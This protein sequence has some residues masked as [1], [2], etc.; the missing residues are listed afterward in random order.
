MPGLTIMRRLRLALL[1]AVLA[2]APV[3]A[4]AEPTRL[5]AMPDVRQHTVYACGAAALQAIIAYYGGDAR[6]DTLMRELG[7]DPKIGTRYWEIVRVAGQYGLTATTE[8]GMSQQR[9]AALIDDG[10]PVILAIQAW[11]S[12]DPR[13]REAWRR[14]TEDGHYLIAIGYDDENFY[15]EDPAIF[16]IGFISRGELA[17]RWHDYD[18][19]GN[20]LERFGILIRGDGHPRYSR[21]PV[22]VN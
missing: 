2:L 7:T 1:L 5:L 17:D 9:L 19:H 11:A 13:D 12:G 21:K 15:F 10:V 20:R 22:P 14:R 16:G 3:A 6:Q 18:E 8:V 4:S